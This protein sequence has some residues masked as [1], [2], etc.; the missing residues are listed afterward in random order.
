MLNTTHC[1]GQ[2]YPIMDGNADHPK[3]NGQFHPISDAFRHSVPLERD[4]LKISVLGEIY[5]V[6]YSKS[7]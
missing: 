5:V 3:V 2:S 7:R 1:D 6:E 4:Q